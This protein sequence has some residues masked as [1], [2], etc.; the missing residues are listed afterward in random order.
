MGFS[1]P[2]ARSSR[3]ETPETEVRMPLAQAVVR[4]GADVMALLLVLA[5]LAVLGRWAMWAAVCLFVYSEYYARMADVVFSRLNGAAALVVDWGARALR[6]LWPFIGYPV[7]RVLWPITWTMH[8]MVWQR[9]VIEFEWPFIFPLAVPWAMEFH[10]EARLVALI[11]IVAPLFTWRVLRDRMKWS[12]WEYTPFGPVDVAEQGIDPHKWGPQKPPVERRG[13]FVV[14]T[15]NFEPHTERVAEGVYRSNGRG[16]AFMLTDFDWVTDEQWTLVAKL[17][18]EQKRPFT[19]MELGR[20]KVFPTH[21]PYDEV[22]GEKL[23]Y[24]FFRKQMFEAGY[25]VTKDGG[26]SVETTAGIE[27]TAAGIEFLT[28]NFLQEGG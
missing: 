2:G 3:Q 16:N 4:G 9:S 23:G 20:G 21:G 19:E 28:R 12:L 17:T 26:K 13:G 5:A 27:L 14:Q 10:T 18:V 7:L 22:Y 11:V 1:Q 8:E 24:R 25:V 6:W 15:T